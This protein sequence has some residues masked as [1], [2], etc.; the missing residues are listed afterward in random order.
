MES[1]SLSWLV[2]QPE[3]GAHHS[4]LFSADINYVCSFTVK[5]LI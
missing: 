4:V 3:N 1:M 2:K 5:L